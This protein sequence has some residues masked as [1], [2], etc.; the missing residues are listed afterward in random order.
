MRHASSL[1]EL[2]NM[3]YPATPSNP[4]MPVAMT[5]A[6]LIISSNC[7]GSIMSLASVGMTAWP[8]NCG[9]VRLSSR[10]SEVE[11]DLPLP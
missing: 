5:K 8:E 6:Q 10:L 9:F 3:I 11:L 7:V 2:P 1:T 4:Y